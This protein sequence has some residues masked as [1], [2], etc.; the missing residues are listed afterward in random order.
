MLVYEDHTRG[1]GIF[2]THRQDG[3]VLIVR[4]VLHAEGEHETSWELSAD[5]FAQLTRALESF[6]LDRSLVPPV[7]LD[8][9]RVLT[10][11]IESIIPPPS[12]HG[13]WS[14]D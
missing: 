7:G 11:A 2:V 9:D 14:F 3:E 6:G 5:Q 12:R 13:W 4:Q 10:A 1:L 8:L